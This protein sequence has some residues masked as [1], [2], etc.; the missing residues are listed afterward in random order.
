MDLERARGIPREGTK[1][2]AH[3]EEPVF[4]QMLLCFTRKHKNKAGELGKNKKKNSMSERE[5]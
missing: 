2:A 4:M 3:R 1:A 5:S